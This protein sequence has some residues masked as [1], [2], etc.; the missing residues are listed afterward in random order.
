MNTNKDKT[1]FNIDHVYNNIF[2]ADTKYTN[3]HNKNKYIFNDIIKEGQQNFMECNFIFIVKGYFKSIENT[4]IIIN[5][6]NG[7]FWNVLI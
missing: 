6:E 3:H 4:T 7:L 2:G 1:K 5:T